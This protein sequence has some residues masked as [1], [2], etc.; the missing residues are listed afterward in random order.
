MHPKLKLGNDIIYLLPIIGVLVLEHP[1]SDGLD[2]AFGGSNT[3]SNPATLAALKH[4]TPVTALTHET[5]YIRILWPLKHSPFESL[6][7]DPVGTIE[8]GYK[9]LCQSFIQPTSFSLPLFMTCLSSFQY[10]NSLNLIYRPLFLFYSFSTCP[11]PL[12]YVLWLL[13]TVF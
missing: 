2:T 4:V 3:A 11:A 10:C 9:C 6:K 5:Y 12:S 8:K 7:V 13:F 1:N